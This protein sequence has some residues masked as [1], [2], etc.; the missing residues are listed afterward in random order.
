M[1]YSFSMAKIKK[2]TRPAQRHEMIDAKTE[3]LLPMTSSTT[4]AKKPVWRNRTRALG[5]L[6]L[7]LLT[8]FFLVKKGFIVAAVVNS[9]PIFRWELNSQLASRFGTQTLESMITERLIADAAQKEGVV[10]IQA[11]VDAKVTTITQT[12]GPNVKL[13]ELLKYQGMTREDFEHQVKL[14]LTVER[15]LGKGVSVEDKEIDAFLKSNRETMIAT[16]DAALR[17]EARDAVFSQ[18]TSEKM[19]PWLLELRDKAKIT[20]LFE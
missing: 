4:W 10:V 18:K 9:K 6:L 12:L 11:D 13:E 17:V 20:K 8:G 5:I 16:D 7:V 1:W 14:Q 15:I 2:S 19:Q 3:D